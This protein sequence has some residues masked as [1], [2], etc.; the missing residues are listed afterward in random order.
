M[1]YKRRLFTFLP[2]L[3]L[4]LGLMA[5][6]S[7]AGAQENVS[8]ASLT[9][10]V[11]PEYDQPAALVFYIGKTAEGT[12]LPVELRFQMPPSAVLNAAA[13]MGDQTGNLLTAA[14]RVDGSI[15]TVTSPNGSFHVEFYDAGLKVEGDRRSYSLVWQ[16]DYAVEQLTWE[17]EQPFGARGMTVEPAGGSWALDSNNLQTYTAGQ[18]GLQAGQPASLSVSYAKPDS[19]LTVDALAPAPS[20][21]A[22]QTTP[23]PSSDTMQIIGLSILIAALSIMIG[24]AVF[25]YLRQ[26]RGTRPASPGTGKRFCTGCGHAAGSEDRFC[27]HCGA[28]LG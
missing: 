1:E 12:T 15:V 25:Y 26:R 13:Y 2:K 22:A 23:T 3:A 18:G 5:P 19:T 16:G 20:G 28:R 27:R 6:V 4:I 9:I 17:V 14:S 8:L 11:W 21:G 7:L 10:R 24:G